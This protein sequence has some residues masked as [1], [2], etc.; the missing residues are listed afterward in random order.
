MDTQGLSLM[1]TLNQNGSILEEYE[2]ILEIGSHSEQVSLAVTN[3]RRLPMLIGH[4]W[5]CKHNPEVDWK[6]GQVIL[7]H[8]PP[9]CRE[10][11]FLATLQAPLT[12][13]TEAKDE[14][15]CILEPGD[16]IFAVY[17]PD[18]EEAVHL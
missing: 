8:C 12:K 1:G 15:E 5:L 18:E 14:E 11:Y 7:S 10:P 9:S 3:L 6:T 16:G 17:L 13:T 2:A 4:T